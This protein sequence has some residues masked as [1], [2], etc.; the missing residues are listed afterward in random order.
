MNS[1]IRGEGLSSREIW[2]QRDQFTN[3][4]IPLQDMQLIKSKN[5]KKLQSH[6]PSSYYKSRGKHQ[7]KYCPIEKGSIVYISSDGSKLKPRD[8]YIVP[9]I[10]KDTCQVQKFVGDQL[11]ARPYQVKRDDIM[12]VQ[13]WRFLNCHEEDGEQEIVRGGKPIK[14]LEDTSEQDDFSETEE[15]V[16]EGSAEEDVP[17]H[18]NEPNGNFTSRSSRKVRPPSLYDTQDPNGDETNE[19]LRNHPREN[20][21]RSG[22]KTKPPDR[23]G[24][25]VSHSRCKKNRKKSFVNRCT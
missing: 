3:E 20:T 25:G 8:R 15:D 2:T 11:R 6:L 22:R 10:S 7:E 16:S 13:P 1:R 9:D 5:D 23:W 24:S 18:G 14:T 19:E 21:T 17:P 4:Q 12:K